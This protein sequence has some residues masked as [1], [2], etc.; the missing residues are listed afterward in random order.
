MY[1]NETITHQS[2]DMVCMSLFDMSNDD[3]FGCVSKNVECHL[4]D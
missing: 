2:T 1:P 3:H 4:C